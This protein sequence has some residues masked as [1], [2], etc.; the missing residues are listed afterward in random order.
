[1]R[2]SKEFL[3]ATAEDI[4]CEFENLLCNNDVKLNN[5]N[6][7]QNKFETEQSYINQK[8]YEELKQKIIEQL[9]D[10][11]DYCQNEAA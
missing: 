1:M 9:K 3:E 7:K 10:I 4:I 6:P 11:V 5:L 8:D 2:V